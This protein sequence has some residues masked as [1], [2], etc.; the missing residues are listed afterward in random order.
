MIQSIIYNYRT[1]HDGTQYFDTY[2]VGEQA[3][4]HS[5]VFVEVDKIEMDWLAMQAEIKAHTSKENG[6]KDVDYVIFQVGV[7]TV[8]QEL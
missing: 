2:T 7:H 8:I 6:E 3:S 1:G 4:L 5:G